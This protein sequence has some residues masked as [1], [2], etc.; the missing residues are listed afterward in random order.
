MLPKLLSQ[1]EFDCIFLKKSM[2]NLMTKGVREEN[3]SSFCNYTSPYVHSSV[4]LS[5]M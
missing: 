2:V 5:C 3:G 4:D 1:F